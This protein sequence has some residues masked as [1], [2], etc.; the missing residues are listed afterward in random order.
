MKKI[1]K[2]ITIVFLTVFLF[3]CKSKNTEEKSIA[4]G[5]D[6]KLYPSDLLGIIPV[7]ASEEDSI[8]TVENYVNNWILQQIML[9]KAKKNLFDEDKEIKN[10][11]DNYRNSLIIFKYQNSLVEKMLDTIIVPQEIQE[12]YDNNK[13]QF[14]LSNNIVKLYF[15]KFAIPNYDK[16]E[17][18]RKIKNTANKL[19]KNV[20]SI[21]K[22]IFSDIS[23]AEDFVKLS[24]LCEK[25]AS[26]FYL[27]YDKWQSMN[28]ILREIPLE[29]HNQQD[30]LKQN[31]V[32]ETYIAPN[33]YLVHITDYKLASEISP[34]EF[35]EDLIKNII[36]NNRKVELLK[37]INSDILKEGK[38][39][40][41]IE[42]NM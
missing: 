32:F 23:S 26:S 39:K 9:A 6:K 8:R 29:I 21:K 7:G 41:D 27:D 22:L 18:A 19:V 5:Y 36:L 37:K 31:H 14:S 1:I 40:K 28:D 15:V 38:E 24:Q 3:S 13:E 33:L 17:K 4:R 11:V 10:L 35:S 20:E 30:F 16:F 25:H 42:V 34:V 12:F 2:Y